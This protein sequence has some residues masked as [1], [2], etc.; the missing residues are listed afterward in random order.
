MISLQRS[1][2]GSN[3]LPYPQNLVVHQHQL[4]QHSYTTT[5][6]T[7]K[8]LQNHQQIVDDNMPWFARPVGTN[9][10]STTLGISTTK[11]AYNGIRDKE[12][13][14]SSTATMTNT[15]KTK[16]LTV[17]GGRPMGGCGSHSNSTLTRSVSP[18]SE[19]ESSLN[20][21]SQEEHYYSFYPSNSEEEKTSSAQHNRYHKNVRD[22][23][24]HLPEGKD[25][26]IQT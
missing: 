8:H 3:F 12:F 21:S 23:E 26:G 2:G 10:V 5:T 18:S 22:S 11:A 25:N 19:E 7:E 1:A 4:H 24:L 6:L 16:N 14:C 13:V 9:G 20:R 17:G 15:A